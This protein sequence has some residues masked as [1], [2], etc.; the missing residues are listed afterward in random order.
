MRLFIWL[1]VLLGSLG[2][3]QAQKYPSSNAAR[4]YQDFQAAM[5]S[6]YGEHKDRVPDLLLK[7]HNLLETGCERQKK[8][9]TWDAEQQIRSLLREL[10]DAHTDLGTSSF[11]NF[12]P[13]EDDLQLTL[14][15]E[16]GVVL[17]HQQNHW[18]VKFVVYGSYADLNGLKQ[19]DDLLS[20]GGRDLESVPSER[21]LDFD[22]HSSLLIDRQGKRLRIELNKDYKEDYWQKAQY[23]IQ[24]DTAILQIPSFYAEGKRLYRNS[25]LPISESV[26]Q[27]LRELQ[28]QHIQN[29]ILDLRYNPG[30]WVNE[31]AAASSAFVKS[32]KVYQ[33]AR[34]TAG[35]LRVQNGQVLGFD[36]SKLLFGVP[37]LP[38]RSAVTSPSFWE[39]KVVVLVNHDTASCGEWF[40]YQLQRA[41]KA[42]V[43]GEPTYGILNTSTQT[44]RLGYRYTLQI[45]VIRSLQEDFTLYPRRITPDQVVHNTLTEDVQL[46][47]ALQLFNP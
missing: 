17:Q 14:E 45:T 36:R 46:Q 12:D 6:Y 5:V 39:P 41:G 26:H 16:L 15:N 28:G 22:R 30:G 42:T 25:Q 23:K 35:F 13:Q 9:Q 34:F 44:R 40:T 1:V 11:F 4:L 19:G 2:A 18:Y 43:I 37:F 32:F 24:Q 8:C 31:C 47:T 20:A 3:A 29:L 7:Y 27:A 21:E 33:D 38:V 10:G